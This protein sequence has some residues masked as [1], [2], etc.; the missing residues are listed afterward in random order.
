MVAKLV[1]LAL[2]GLF[3]LAWTA[4]LARAEVLWFWDT[5]EVSIFSGVL[6]L[7]EKD[8]FLCVVVVLFAIVAPYLKTLTLVYAQ[9]SDSETADRV[10]PAIELLGRLSMI[11]VFLI[12]F[13]IVLYRGIADVQIAWGLYLF[14]ALVLASMWAAWA[15]RHERFEYVPRRRREAGGEDV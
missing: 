15:T 8:F 3:P 2:I 6:E 4:P 1:N 10:M 11:D 12:A 14:T 5:D 9:F 7:Y 13:Y